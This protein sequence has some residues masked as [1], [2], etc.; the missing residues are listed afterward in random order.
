MVQS[1]EAVRKTP[2][3]TASVRLLHLFFD[4]ATIDAATER[5]LAD[6]GLTPADIADP[7]ARVPHAVLE[8]LLDRG[9][10]VARDPELGL[11]LAELVRPGAFDVLE[12]IARTSPTLGDAVLGLS[13]YHRVLHDTWSIG[14]AVSDG[15]AVV[16]FGLRPPLRLS[17]AA[18]EFCMA[19]L[20]LG[21]RR[22]F[23]AELGV[24]EV[25]FAHSAPSDTREHARI[26]GAPVRFDAGRNSV[27]FRATE[28]GAVLPGADRDLCAVL[29]RHARSMV[30]RL[31]AATTYADRVRAQILGE[32]PRGSPTLEGA[33]KVLGASP[34]TVRRRLAAEST[35]YQ[36]L[37]DAVRRE[38]GLR[39]L[40][41][42]LT[43]EEVA[44]A[45]GFSDP[46]AFRRAFRRWTGRTV[47]QHRRATRD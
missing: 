41:E 16:E 4:P 37:L 6:V 31:P 25:C 19:T 46:S 7:D 5:L 47:A 18:A 45:L 29:E 15:A 14:L 1:E 26:F 42:S 22:I 28:L 11:H 23:R 44:Y 38:L 17:R 3:V 2:R 20:F 24:L 21:A 43:V 36:A 35:T 30:E 10:E 32:L 9:I 40:D 13:R 12:C 34:R 39:Y 27:S 33:A 8:R